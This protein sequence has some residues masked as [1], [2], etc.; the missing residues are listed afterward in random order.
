M[1]IAGGYYKAVEAAAALNMDCVQIFSK[2]NNQWR[3]KPLTDDDAERFRDALEQTGVQKP[4]AHDSYLINLA[5]PKPDVRQKSIDAFVIELERAEKLGLLG[6]VMHPGS[7][8]DSS[9]EEGLQK[10]VDG[11]DIVLEQTDGQ[12]VEVWLET[13]AGQGTNLGHRFEH[14]GH[15]IENV[16]DSSRLGVCIDSCHIFSAGYAI[17]EPAEYH[18]TMAEFDRVIGIDRIR[19]FH[20]N[21]SKK[22]FASRVDR[23]EHIGDGYLGLEP[24]RHIVNDPRFAETPMYMET[25]KGKGTDEFDKRN[26][27]TLRG[28]LTP[29]S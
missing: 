16:A 6:V 11:L 13:T 26:L 19:A 24:F 21:D 2:N 25:P 29:E 14:L 10:I 20:L 12:G 3:A 4:C 22:E 27:K 5:S 28:L 8:L 1:S 23:H 17:T 9:E 7:F 15:I 18:K